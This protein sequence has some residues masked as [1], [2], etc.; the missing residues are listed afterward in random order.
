P[1]A[2]PAMSMVAAPT[3]F[4]TL[5]ADVAGLFPPRARYIGNCMWTASPLAACFPDFA[6]HLAAAPSVKSFS[7]AVIYPTLAH[8]ARPMPDAAMAL[9]DRTL[10]LWYAIWDDAAG[11]ADNRTWYRGAAD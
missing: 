6:K 1:G 4:N 2:A 7:N 8:G 5:L 9:H 10:V 11:D 3:D